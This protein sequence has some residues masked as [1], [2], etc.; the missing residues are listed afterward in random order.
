MSGTYFLRTVHAGDGSASVADRL[1]SAVHNSGNLFFE[2]AVSRHLADAVEVSDIA[3][4]PRGARRLVLSMSNFISPATDLGDV[5]DDIERSGVEQVVMIGAGAQAESYERP[6]SVTP[7]TRRFLSI[8]SER[9]HSIGVRGHFTADV[10]DRMGVRNVDVIG[11][12]SLFYHG[13]RDFQVQKRDVVGR[14][15]R[16]VTHMTPYGNLRD[17]CSHLLSFAVRECRAYIAQSELFLTF[18]PELERELK[19][20]LMYFADGDV[21][22]AEMEDWLRERVCWFFD[23]ESWIRYMGDVDFAVG[24]R[25]HGNMAA[26]LAGTPALNLVQDART[27]ELCEYL[28]LP[29]RF[30]QDFDGRATARELYETTDFS[31]FNA[32]FPVKYDAYRRFLERNGL[33]TTLGGDSVDMSTGSGRVRLESCLELI[34]SAQAAGFDG[35][36]LGHEL[37]SRIRQERSW[38]LMKLAES[39]KFDVR[40]QDS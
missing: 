24:G 12:P 30:L 29:Y 33:Q 22:A 3:D 1:A 21:Q 8:L 38:A 26:I 36:R 20:F 23:I 2:G 13:A 4:V 37:A 15:L 40:R 16:T 10:L 11:C 19:Y 35:E 34:R 32:T 6:V 17:G 27:R 7:G 39:G 14:N 9:S 31:L 25:F 5:A 28:N 18:A